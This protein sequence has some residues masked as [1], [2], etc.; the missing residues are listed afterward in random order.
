MVPGRSSRRDPAEAV[1]AGGDGVHVLPGDVAEVDPD[2]GDGPDLHHKRLC[3]FRAEVVTHH[4]YQSARSACLTSPVISDMGIAW[5]P[6]P[7]VLR[8]AD[9]CSETTAC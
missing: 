2:G 6:G 5:P 9:R 3:R 8:G 7:F 1:D 4:P